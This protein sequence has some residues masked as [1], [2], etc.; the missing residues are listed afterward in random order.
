MRYMRYMR[1][2]RY[3]R[4]MRYMRYM[5]YLRYMRYMRYMRY[6]EAKAEKV[7]RCEGPPHLLG[8]A[9]LPTNPRCCD[10]SHPANSPPAATTAS[11]RGSGGVATRTSSRAPSCGVSSSPSRGCAPRRSSPSAASWTSSWVASASRAPAC[12][13][14]VTPSSRDRTRRRSR[15]RRRTIP[16]SRTQRAIITIRTPSGSPTRR[17]VRLE[18]NL[19]RRKRQVAVSWLARRRVACPW[20]A[21]GVPMA[22][23]SLGIEKTA[24]KRLR[25]ADVRAR[26]VGRHRDAQR[27]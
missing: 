24:N 18:C 10:C 20:R 17:A 22:C 11:R 6:I 13:R 1:Y 12:R 21:R 25:S 19:N 15:R 3:L 7:R 8:F 26:R 4:Y 16:P 9:P 5:R 14:S 23:P 27:V 2:L